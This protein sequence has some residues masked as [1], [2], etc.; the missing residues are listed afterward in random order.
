MA[1]KLE[2]SGIKNTIIIEDCNGACPMNSGT[3]DCSLFDYL[4]QCGIDLP[5]PDMLTDEKIPANCP[6]PDYDVADALRDCERISEKQDELS[7]RQE[8]IRLSG[9]EKK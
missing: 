9:L 5:E 8:S 4:C 2:I 1:K 3:F 7:M 6:L